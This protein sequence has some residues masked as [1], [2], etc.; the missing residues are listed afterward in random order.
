MKINDHQKCVLAF[1]GIVFVGLLLGDRMVLSFEAVLV[2]LGF[3]V[4]FCAARDKVEPAKIKSAS[5][6]L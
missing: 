6:R 4:W 3:F 1:V 2:W 5:R